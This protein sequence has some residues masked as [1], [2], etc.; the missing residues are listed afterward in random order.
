MRDLANVFVERD[1]VEEYTRAMRDIQETELKLAQ[2]L[3]RHYAKA[4]LEKRETGKEPN[5]R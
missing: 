5:R 1:P 2:V 4:E 3:S